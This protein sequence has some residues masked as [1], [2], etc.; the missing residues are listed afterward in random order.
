[1]PLIR[2][3]IN[4]P[5]IV[6]LSLVIVMIMGILAWRELPQEIFPVVDLD[7]VHIVTEFDGA[8]PAEVEQQVTLP[9]E[10][11]FEDSQDIDYISSI[12]RESLSSIFIKLKPGSNVDDF[13]RDAR[14]ILDSIDDLPDIAEEPEL[15]RIRTRFPVIT[16]TLFGDISN[17]RL[18]ELTEDVRRRMQEIE[19]VAS[20]GVAG[21][22][23]WEI[24]VTVDPYR[25]AAMSVSLDSVLAVLRN[26]L[27]DQPG[28]S[29]KSSE[30]DIRLRGKGV[31]PEPAAVGPIG[32]STPATSTWDDQSGPSEVAV[33]SSGKGAAGL[34]PIGV[35]TPPA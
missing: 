19:G 27:V 2:F 12:S 6:N 13:M 28:G 35:S 20:V 29:I 9:L 18:Y 32:V 4:N 7:M 15:N 14:T 10:E 33:L 1:M 8:S 22:R 25:L 11:E 5:L 34:G 30:G 21:D 17:A 3:S 24:W 23:E 16:L 26:N 31:E